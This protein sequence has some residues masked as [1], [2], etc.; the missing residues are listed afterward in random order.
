MEI[1]HLFRLSFAFL[2][3]ALCNSYPAS[4]VATPDGS[5]F[6]DP[7]G[8][9]GG[10]VNQYIVKFKTED[11]YASF[12]DVGVTDTRIKGSLPQLDTALMHFDSEE[13]AQTW[14]ATRDD[15]EFVE[16]GEG[17][18]ISWFLYS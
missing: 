16:Q 10:I 5:D 17:E 6:P 4:A 9:E 18:A 12:V 15:I 14:A 11:S 7:G 13:E 2:A 3:S 8:E 1:S